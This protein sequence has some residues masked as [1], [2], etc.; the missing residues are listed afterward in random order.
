MTKEEYVVGLGSKD[1]FC[2]RLETELKEFG[3]IYGSTSMKFGLYY[4]ESGDDSEEKYRFSKKYG[5]TVDEVL[6]E[7]KKQIIFLRMDGEKKDYEAI[8]KC[9]LPPLI[10]GKILSVFFPEDYLCIFAEE[11][12]DYFLK[13][14]G[15]NI[16]DKDDVLVK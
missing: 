4:G 5:S 11:H 13:K 9:E 12:L 14:L 6:E 8:R 1:S 7:L 15:M 3:N 10:R 16:E 2:Y